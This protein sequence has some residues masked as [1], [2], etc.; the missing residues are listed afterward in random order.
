MPLFVFSEPPV[1]QFVALPGLADNKPRQQGQ[2][3]SKKW[4]V[5]GHQ[6]PKPKAQS[7]KPNSQN[8]DRVVG[9][10]VLGLGT[11]DFV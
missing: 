11:W 8:P 1:A 2:E 9:I 7:P 10:R 3:G 5:V 6:I 4:Q